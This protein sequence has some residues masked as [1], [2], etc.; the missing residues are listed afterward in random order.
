M[1]FIGR[2][3]AP[4]PISAND[5]PDLPASKITSGTFSDARIAASNVSQHATSFDDNNIVNDLST[6]GLRVHTQENLNASNSNSASFDVFQDSSGITNLTNVARDSGEFVSSIT[7]NQYVRQNVTG[8]SG[9]GGN[10]AGQYSADN[11]SAI[12]RTRDATEGGTTDTGVYSNLAY[13]T[14][15]SVSGYLIAD[16]GASYSISQLI[17]GKGRSHGDARS[18]KIRYHATQS[19]PQANGTDVDFTNAVST[20]YSYKNSSANLSNF[21]STGTA[22]WG[23]LSSNAD[24]VACKING[25]TPFTA[26]YISY[27]FGS[28]D[29]HDNNAGW[30][31]FDIYKTTLVGNATGSFEG[32]TITA[33]SSTSSMGAVLTYEDNVGSN[34]LNTDI[35]LKLS[36]NNG[37]NYTTATLTALP[38]F[39]TG[40]KMA[41]VNDLSV[42]S[43]TQLKYKIEFANQNTGSKVA[44]IRGVSLQY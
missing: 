38:D 20:V 31:E 1:G 27:K 40:I 25:F 13:T 28:A 18:I 9:A 10:I 37:S 5:V 6:L 8:L 39:A 41:K 43:G 22:D 15:S 33:S 19:D 29:F 7:G 21:S 35:V 30:S 2:T 3:V 12:A 26:R 34:S 32:A 16:L 11:A 36:A 23:A 24:G 42:T 44:R 4:A 14:T 17:L